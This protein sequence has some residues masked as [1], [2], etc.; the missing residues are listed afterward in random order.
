MIKALIFSN[1]L[2]SWFLL[3]AHWFLLGDGEEYCV[4]NRPT[5]D[6][7]GEI[8]KQSGSKFAKKERNKTIS[9]QFAL[10]PS[11]HKHS[12]HVFEKLNRYMCT[13]KLIQNNKETISQ[14]QREFKLH[15][16]WY[17]SGYYALFLPRREW[18]RRQPAKRHWHQTTAVKAFFCGKN[19]FWHHL[20]KIM[21]TAADI[22]D[23]RSLTC[24]H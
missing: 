23:I 9:L 3:S 8:N 16:Y 4:C 15:V 14:I 11:E 10:R 1:F 6:K 13:L 17:A 2:I 7:Y 19:A 5:Q 12:R 22:Y 18:C 20:L 21:L 24:W